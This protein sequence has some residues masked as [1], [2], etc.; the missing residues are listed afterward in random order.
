M[1]KCKRC[2]L[3]K[4]LDAFSL[5]SGFKDGR[6]SV[7]KEC[8]NKV[9]KQTYQRDPARILEKQRRRRRR[10][11]LRRYGI[12][13]TEYTVLFE[14]QDGVCA[15]CGKAQFYRPLAVDHDHKTG[16][17]RGLLCD[18]CNWVIGLLKDD[19]TILERGATYLRKRVGENSEHI[20]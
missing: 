20:E 9:A 2:Q 4:P 8:K 13:E 3:E 12:T 14:S 18:R 11:T 5:H 10:E 6:N 1:K 16:V 19:P 17:I 7:C 15:I